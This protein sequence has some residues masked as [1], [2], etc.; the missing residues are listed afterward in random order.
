MGGFTTFLRECPKC[1]FWDQDQL[2][3]VQVWFDVDECVTTGHQTDVL[4]YTTP[5]CP[6]GKRCGFFNESVLEVPF[7]SNNYGH[8]PSL[9]ITLQYK[10]IS[11]SGTIDQGI[12][13]NDCF[14]KGTGEY[15]PGNSLFISANDDEF[16]GGLKDLTG[17]TVTVAAHGIGSWGLGPI[18]ESHCPLMIGAFIKVRE[19]SYFQ[20][21]MDNICFYKW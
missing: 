9:R 15:A 6:Q 5:N 13:S 10:M 17:T 16:N 2:T 1:S 21:Y 18:R 7:F 8:W 14:P 11:F 12:V 20:G 19:L 4:N 3:C